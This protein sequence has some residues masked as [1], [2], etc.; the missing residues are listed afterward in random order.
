MEEFLVKNFGAVA[1]VI[2]AVIGA[3]A[4]IYVAR[5]KRRTDASD[6]STTTHQTAPGPGPAAQ[7]GHARDV[8]IHQGA[9]TGS[10][11]DGIVLSLTETY[12]DRFADYETRLTDKDTEIAALT[13][14]VEALQAARD[15]ADAPEDIDEALSQLEA[16]DTAKAEEIFRGVLERRRA[17]GTDAYKEAAAAARH[18][19]ALAFLHDDTDA[20]LRAYSEAVELDPDDA[21]GWNR[22]GQLRH[23]A[24]NLDGAV[25]AYERSFASGM[26][27]ATSPSSPT[28]ISA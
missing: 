25:D 1:T 28:A 8:T 24:G 21:D 13:G 26:L 6:G 18:L 19:G 16:G 3:A 22:L 20:A 9:D 5:R 2:A 4:L 27:P 14:A 15:S 23:R 10:V 12:L 7:F 17:E 11:T